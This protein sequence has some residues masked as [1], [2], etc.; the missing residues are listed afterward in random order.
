MDQFYVSS[1]CLCY[2]KMIKK[3][4][5]KIQDLDKFIEKTI[6]DQYLL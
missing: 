2:N 3:N 5:I 6:T 4:S 1:P